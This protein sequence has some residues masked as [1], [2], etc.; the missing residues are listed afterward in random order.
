MKELMPALIK[1]H[2]LTTLLQLVELDLAKQL[3]AKQHVTVSPADIQHERE[4]TLSRLFQQTDDKMQQAIEDAKAAH[5]EK[6]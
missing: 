5:D 1:A 2:G 6:R 3:A 4:V